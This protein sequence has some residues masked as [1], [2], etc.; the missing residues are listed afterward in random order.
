MMA[1]ID[2]GAQKIYL[3]GQECEVDGERKVLRFVLKSARLLHG[4]WK[5]YGWPE[6]M[7]SVGLNQ[8]ILDYSVK[9]DLIIEVT[10]GRKVTSTYYF[11][12][13]DAEKVLESEWIS[14]ITNGGM[15]VMACPLFMTVRR[16]ASAMAKAESEKQRVIT[17]YG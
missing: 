9:N 11:T 12:P 6:H 17:E 14:I 5:K 4:L 8:L 2:A 10:L 13:K 1:Q 16:L 3:G 15:K 7:P